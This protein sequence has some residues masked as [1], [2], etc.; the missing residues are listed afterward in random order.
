[1]TDELRV[2]ARVNLDTVQRYAEQALAEEADSHPADVMMT[3]AEIIGAWLV[4]H[5]YDD[6]L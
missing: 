2:S 1:M 4:G 5:G 3:V 6:H